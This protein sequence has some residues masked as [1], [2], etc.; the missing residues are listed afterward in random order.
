MSDLT[1]KQVKIKVS[2]FIIAPLKM[3]P[4]IDSLKGY[5][6]GIISKLCENKL[7]VYSNCYTN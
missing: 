5:I 1:K 7:N 4:L 2:I 3:Y 6:T